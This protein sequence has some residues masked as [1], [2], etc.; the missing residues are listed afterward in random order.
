MEEAVSKIRGGSGIS[1]PSVHS[2]WGSPSVC[3]MV[4][5]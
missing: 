2:L 5:I 3:Q 1:T 4:N